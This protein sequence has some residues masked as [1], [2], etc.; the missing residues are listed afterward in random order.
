MVST[1]SAAMGATSVKGAAALVSGAAEVPP[2]M[3]QEMTVAV[4]P[5]VS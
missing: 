3:L 5:P 4:L 1:S 2:A